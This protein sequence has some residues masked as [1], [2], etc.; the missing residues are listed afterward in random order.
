LGA[1]Y[2]LTASAGILFKP[3]DI[4]LDDNKQASGAFCD[5][6]GVLGAIELT[7]P[8]FDTTVLTGNAGL[9]VV[10]LKNAMRANA[11]AGGAAGALFLIDVNHLKNLR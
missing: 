9:F 11:G 10:Y 1:G 3:E 6:D 7:C 2:L 4:L 8:A 5:R